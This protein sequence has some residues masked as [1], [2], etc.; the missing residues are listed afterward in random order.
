[1]RFFGPENVR[2]RF[3]AFRST[4]VISTFVCGLHVWNATH[5]LEVSVVMNLGGA[6]TVSRIAVHERQERTYRENEI[7]S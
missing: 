6:E 3:H 2:T 4:A 1:M 7:H 5:L